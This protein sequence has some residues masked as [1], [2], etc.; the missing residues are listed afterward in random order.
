[1]FK[2]ARTLPDN[3]V[4][5]GRLRYDTIEEAELAMAGRFPFDILRVEEEKPS[6]GAMKFRYVSRR[7]RRGTEWVRSDGEWLG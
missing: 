5:I 2:V 6:S 7:E 4:V 3:S 1:M